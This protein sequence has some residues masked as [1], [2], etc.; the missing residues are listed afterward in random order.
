MDLLGSKRSLQQL[1]IE[2]VLFN[3]VPGLS[4]LGKDFSTLLVPSTVTGSDQVG[5]SGGL[6]ETKRRVKLVLESLMKMQTNKQLTYPFG[7]R[8]KTRP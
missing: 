3:V 8:G 6:R 2:V 1:A 4:S 7:S 5:H